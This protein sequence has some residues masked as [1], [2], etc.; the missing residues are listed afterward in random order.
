[1]ASL[2]HKKQ[3]TKQHFK[4]QEKAR[5]SITYPLHTYNTWTLMRHNIKKQN[6]N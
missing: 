3:L 1:M 6:N 2:T 4:Q 5:S